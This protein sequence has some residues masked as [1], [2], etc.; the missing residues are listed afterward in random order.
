MNVFLLIEEYEQDHYQNKR[1]E[2]ASPFSSIVGIYQDRVKAEREK[3]SLELYKEK[4]DLC[5]YFIE[6]RPVL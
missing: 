3:E 4:N 1:K 5:S 2:P 6:E